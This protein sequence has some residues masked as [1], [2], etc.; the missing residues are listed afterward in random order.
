MLC[1]FVWRDRYADACDSAVA[2][3]LWTKDV[4]ASW[5]CVDFRSRRVRPRHYS[6][7]HGGLHC[8]DFLRSWDLQASLDGARWLVLRKQTADSS[9]TKPFG[10]CTWEIPHCFRSYR[11]FRV[12][13]TGHNSSRHNFLAVSGIE[14]YGELRTSRN[15]ADE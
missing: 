10:V 9:L 5:F 7:R 15:A 6:L 14:F 4:P 3:E 12:I 1:V 11:Y 13:Q 2:S 8:T